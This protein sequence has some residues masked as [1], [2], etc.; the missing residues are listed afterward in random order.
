MF[1]CKPLSSIG[2]FQKS[3]SHG[4][5]MHL[6]STK[7][8]KILWSHLSVVCS[9]IMP[10]PN[11]TVCKKMNVWYQIYMCIK[12]MFTLYYLILSK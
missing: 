5:G 1:Q 10:T 12:L 2:R 6:V 4:I 11:F 3:R 9:I 7:L 8:S